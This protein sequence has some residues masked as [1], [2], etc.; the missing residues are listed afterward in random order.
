MSQ[1]RGKYN[2]KPVDADGLHFDSRA[3]AAR[4]WE[5]TTLVR[6]GE[7]AELKPHPRFTI[8]E[9]VTAKGK[10]E[11]ITYVADFQ[12]TEGGRVVVED[13]KGGSATQTAVWKM[14]RKMFVCRYPDIDFRVVER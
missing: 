6:A 4:Y 13:V 14:K 11:K 7:I 12:Y 8:W 3:E 10:R 2:A 5:L 1:R 9:G